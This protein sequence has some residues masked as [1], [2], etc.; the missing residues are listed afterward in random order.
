MASFGKIDG[1]L[2]LA[3][4]MVAALAA[5]LGGLQRRFDGSDVRKGVAAAMAF[6]PRPGGASVFEAL[7]ARGEGDPRCDGEVVSAVLGDVAVRCATPARPEIW[8]AFRVLLDGMLPPKP[9]GPAAE[10]LVL[11]LRG[12]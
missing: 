3:L 2:P 11:E 12:P 4:A 8:Y 9:E 10:G 1:R 7:V 5:A 6:R